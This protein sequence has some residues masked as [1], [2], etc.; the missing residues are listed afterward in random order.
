[1]ER[2]TIARLKA[3][4][5]SQLARDEL[6]K[7]ITQGALLPGSRLNEVHLSEQLGVSRGPLREAARELEGL[8]LTTS[9]PNQGFYIADFTDAEII[10]LYEASPWIHQGLVKDFLTYAAPSAAQ[11][12]LLDLN[13][14]TT[15]NVADFSEELLQFRQRALAHVHNRYLAEMALSLYRRFY[16]VAALVRANDGETRMEK[17]IETQRQFWTAIA[18]GKAEEA[19][20]IILA[21]CQFWLTD[22]PPRFARTTLT[23]RS[24]T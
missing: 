13:S 23:S 14:V 15:R 21:D 6:I 24:G 19:L 20:E 9:R 4:K 12:I 18:N 17:I 1:M 7:L 2:K 5:L 11:E 10:E 22:I 8:G 16:I 3:P